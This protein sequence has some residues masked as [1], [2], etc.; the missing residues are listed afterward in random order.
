MFFFKRRK[1]KKRRK[2]SIWK[3]ENKIRCH[4]SKTEYSNFISKLTE[5][6]CHA[7]IIRID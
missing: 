7:I 5:K 2:S 6:G 3:V 1:H 4:L